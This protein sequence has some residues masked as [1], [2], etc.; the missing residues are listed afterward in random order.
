LVGPLV[1]P[2][3]PARNGNGISNEKPCFFAPPAPGPFS[4]AP[5][6][7]WEPLPSGPGAPE[8]PPSPPP[9]GPPCPP[10]PRQ[11]VRP[12]WGPEARNKSLVCGW[13]TGAPLLIAA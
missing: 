9:P 12:P 10:P 1:G 8:P 6:E 4:P 11:F 13:P 3:S 7:T 2:V 5:E